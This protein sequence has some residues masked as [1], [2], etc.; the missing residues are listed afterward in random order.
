MRFSYGLPVALAGAVAT[1]TL[2]QPYIALAKTSRQVF[3]IANAIT[4]L[5]EGHPSSGPSSFGSGVIVAKQGKTYTVL[6]AKHVVE[7]KNKKY[8]VVTFDSKGNP[9]T[10]DGNPV[11]YSTVNPMDGV[12]LAVL[13]FTS[14][15][16]YSVASLGNSAQATPGTKVYVAGFPEPGIEIKKR[17]LDFKD[18]IISRSS[19]TRDGYD[20]IYSNPTREGMSGG[21]VLDEDGKLVGIHGRGDG[22]KRDSGEV[23]KN[24]DNLGIPINTFLNWASKNELHLGSAAPVAQQ[25]SSP[26]APRPSAATAPPALRWGYQNV[27]TGIYECLDQAYVIMQKDSFKNLNYNKED[28]FVSG[29]AG[30]YAVDISCNSGYSAIIVAGPDKKTAG[31][32][33]DRFWKAMAPYRVNLPP[34]PANAPASPATPPPALRWTFEDNNM[35]DDECVNKAYRIMQREGLKNI[36]KKGESTKQYVSG[37]ADNYAADISCNTEDWMVVV[38]GA[39]KATAK[40]WRDKLRDGMKQ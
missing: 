16:T 23:V 12:D 2:V 33:L 15:K 26:P 14:D 13:Q 4:V 1:V 37:F 24:G 31:L 6:T 28:L 38:T 20:L 8:K 10:K 32:W 11:N 25:P 17:I 21:P 27:N 39:D 19:N 22:Y 3:G 18:G 9:D 7:N 35:S 30:S 29:I 40:R 34:R 36:T 5:I